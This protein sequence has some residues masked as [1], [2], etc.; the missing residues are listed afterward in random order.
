[1][2]NLCRSTLPIPRTL[3][4]SLSLSLTPSLIA[5]NPHAPTSLDHHTIPFRSSLPSSE[6]YTCFIVIT[7][8][9]PSQPLPTAFSLSG[10]HF[11]KLPCQIS[12]FQVLNAAHHNKISEERFS[13]NGTAHGYHGSARKRRWR[14][15]CTTNEDWERNL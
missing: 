15:D 5:I 3:S 7:A 14:A 13:S 11:S 10:S 1:M 2:L 12:P 6:M 4:L 9:P 8:T